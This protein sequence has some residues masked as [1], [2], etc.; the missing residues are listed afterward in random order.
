VQIVLTVQIVHCT[1][2]IHNQSHVAK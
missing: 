2:T 1:L